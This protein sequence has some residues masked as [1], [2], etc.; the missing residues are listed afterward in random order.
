MDKSI[1]ALFS[2]FVALLPKAGEKLLTGKRG[3]PSQANVEKFLSNY[4]QRLPIQARALFEANPFLAL[5][6]LNAYR[7]DVT[8]AE[9]AFLED[10]SDGVFQGMRNGEPVQTESRASFNVL[11]K[12]SESLGEA[13]E[14][15]LEIALAAAK[16]MVRRTGQTHY[17]HFER[18]AI[19]REVR[20]G[21]K[22]LGEINY[23]SLLNLPARYQGILY[24]TNSE[25]KV[26]FLS[27]GE[28]SPSG[29]FVKYFND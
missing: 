2:A 3:R 19:S 25:A 8:E 14:Q 24:V 16:A 26:G 11:V 1:V 22:L 6:M 29:K 20:G 15:T 17:I 5:D 9:E 7:R 4:A 21:R 12:D 28:V 18:W 27:L 13:V 23:D 10:T